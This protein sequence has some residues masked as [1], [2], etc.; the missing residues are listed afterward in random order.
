MLQM[1]PAQQQ[2]LETAFWRG[3]T[4][5]KRLIELTNRTVTETGWRR[6]FRK[7][8]FAEIAQQAEEIEEEVRGFKDWIEH[9]IIAEISDAAAD[10]PDVRA[11]HALFDWVVALHTAADLMSKKQR[12]FRDASEGIKELTLKETVRLN[13]EY[14][15]AQAHYYQ[16]GEKLQIAMERLREHQEHGSVAEQSPTNLVE[17]AEDA[18]L[19]FRILADTLRHALERDHPQFARC[20]GWPQFVMAATVG[21]CV[22]LAIRLHYDVAQD[23]RTELE[24]KLREVLSRRFPRSEVAYAACYRFVTESLSEITRPERGKYLFVLIAMWVIGVVTDAQEIDEHEYVMARIAELYQNETS[25]YWS[26]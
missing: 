13:A 18:P 7:F 26:E 2:K 8:P 21:G 24:L 16:L 15:R 14:D 19:S 6:I 9:E 17:K 23:R 20:P 4:L 5:L 10:A 12:V 3:E 11:A 25:G 22:S 1:R